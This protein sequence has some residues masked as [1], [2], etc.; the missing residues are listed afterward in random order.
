MTLIVAYELGLAL[1]T[2]SS[3]LAVLLGGVLATS[4]WLFLP[5]PAVAA[6]LHA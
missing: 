1:A 4:A 3:L 5:I 2:T 6:I